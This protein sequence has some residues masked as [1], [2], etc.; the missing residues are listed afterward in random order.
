MNFL[1]KKKIK[2]CKT[3]NAIFRNLTK[4]VRDKRTMLIPFYLLGIATFIGI[5]FNVIFV[6]T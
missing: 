6:N 1:S 4:I 2:L 3:K 5:V